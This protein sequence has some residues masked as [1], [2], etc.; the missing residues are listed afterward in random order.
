MR[1]YNLPADDLFYKWESFVI[2]QLKTTSDKKAVFNLE[3]ARELKK[4]I[5]RETQ[6]AKGQSSAGSGSSG[7]M[8]TPASKL[9]GFGGSVKRTGMETDL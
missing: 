9:G 4:H 8:G 5:Q 3:H 2:N 6:Q 7:M 1:M